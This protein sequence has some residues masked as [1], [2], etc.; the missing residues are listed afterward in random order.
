MLA[1]AEDE[2]RGLADLQC[3]FG[4]DNGIRPAADTVRTEILANHDPYP[5]KRRRSTPRAG[6]KR[7]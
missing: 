6:Y 3:E 1:V 7:S 5:C 2:T 4:R